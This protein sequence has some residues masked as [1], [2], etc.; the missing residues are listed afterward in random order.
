M[1]MDLIRYTD[2]MDLAQVNTLKT[3]VKALMKCACSATVVQAIQTD[4]GDINTMQVKN[5][6]CSCELKLVPDEDAQ[7]LYAEISSIEKQNLYQIASLWKLQLDRMQYKFLHGKTKQERENDY[8]FVVDF[9][10]E[11]MV[12]ELVF[13]LSM[14]KIFLYS[15]H[16]EKD[17]CIVLAAPINTVLFG[18]GRVSA[19]ELEY[20]MYLENEREMTESPSSER[21]GN[22]W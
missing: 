18:I 8:A 6:V 22:N 11:N 15:W 10:K 17:D 13:Q 12:E 16:P 19:Q 14:P 3:V 20:S 1:I 7:L 9:V 5:V 21:E 4:K 2:P